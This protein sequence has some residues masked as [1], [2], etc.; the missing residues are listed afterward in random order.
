LDPKAFLAPFGPYGEEGGERED[1]QTGWTHP[2]FNELLEKADLEI[3][4]T[5]RD[6]LFQEAEKILLQ[7]MPIIPIY[8]IEGL[9]IQNP[10]LKNVLITPLGTA[11]FKSAYFEES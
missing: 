4:L 2:Q 1:N 9:Y 7:E 8:F 5:Q 6:H 11:D 10:Q 3:D